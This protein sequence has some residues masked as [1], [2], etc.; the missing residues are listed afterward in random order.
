MN[1][2]TEKQGIRFQIVPQIY[3]VLLNLTKIYTL[4]GKY[5]DR[6]WKFLTCNEMYLITLVCIHTCV[7]RESERGKAGIFPIVGLF[8]ETR[9][10]EKEENDRE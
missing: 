1:I 8:E 5:I 3:R 2:S 4:H 9:E 10:E 6:N 7:W